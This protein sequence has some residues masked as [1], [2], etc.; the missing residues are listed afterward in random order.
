MDFVN[1]PGTIDPESRMWGGKHPQDLRVELVDAKNHYYTIEKSIKK[2][3][4]NRVV[5]KYI[6]VLTHNIFDYSDKKNFRRETLL[7]VIKAVKK[8][9]A[10]NDCIFTPANT[11]GIGAEY[12]KVIPLPEGGVKL[13]LD[14]RGRK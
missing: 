12:R 7:G 13:E 9:R 4:E 6:K 14:T 8:I 11:M 2:Q 10:E 5:V 1:I 3:I